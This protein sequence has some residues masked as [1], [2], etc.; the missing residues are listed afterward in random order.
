MAVNEIAFHIGRLPMGEFT[1][2][3][4]LDGPVD[5]LTPEAENVATGTLRLDIYLQADRLEDLDQ[6]IERVLQHHYSGSTRALG[7]KYQY[8]HGGEEM[9]GGVLQ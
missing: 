5:F 7:V 8:P 1:A 6:A 3:G 9:D 4:R 2:K